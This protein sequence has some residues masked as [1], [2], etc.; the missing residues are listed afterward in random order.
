MWLRLLPLLTTLLEVFI[1]I[2]KSK[3]SDTEPINPQQPINSVEPVNQVPLPI[4]VP[5][6]NKEFRIKTH[7]LSA[8][9][10][11][12]DNTFVPNQI[13][14]HH[15]AGASW[16][17]TYN[18]WMS[19]KDRICT[20]FLVERDGTIVQCIPLDKAWGFHINVAA[21]DNKIPINYKNIGRK[22]DKQSIG[23]ELCNM[24]QLVPHGDKFL[25]IYNKV[26]KTPEKIIKL[27][28]AFR[29]YQFFEDYTKQQIDALEYL[30]LYLM[31]EYPKIADGLKDNY[32]DQFEVS[33]DA[34]DMKPGVY[35]HVN[36]RSHNKWDL[37]PHPYLIEMLNGLKN[38]TY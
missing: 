24:S 2:F 33:K 16:E 5:V 19:N 20:H 32:S 15:T 1:K 26:F 3:S 28:K 13:V 23:I 29:G 31:K 6:T 7:L 18:Y 38:K 36:Y 9:Q 30:L 12:Q 27:D 37:Y 10:Y 8:N 21:P 11:V 4:Q 34:L 17:S 35:F 14:L 22:Y 25:D